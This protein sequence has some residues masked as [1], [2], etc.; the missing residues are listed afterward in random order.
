MAHAGLGS[1]YLL[2]A[3]TAMLRP[4]PADEAMPLARQA[5]ERALALDESLAE[6]WAVLGRVKMEYDWDW[7]GAEADLAPCRRAQRQLGRG[8]R[9]VRPVPERDGPPRR[10]DRGDA[11]GAQARPAPRRDAAASRHRLLDGRAGRALDR[12]HGRK[13]EGRRHAARPL[14]PHDGVRPARPPRR[15]D[16]R[17]SGHAARAGRRPGPCR[18]RRGRCAHRELARG[19]GGMDRPARAHQPLGRSR[20]YN[21]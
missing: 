3:S 6:A 2:M 17:A 20:P 15:G 8:A 4:L 16:G 13:P 7:E 18:S 11:A 12:D 10:G 5:A 1:T 19:D 9:H 14:W 21:G